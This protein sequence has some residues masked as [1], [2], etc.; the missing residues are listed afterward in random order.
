M[1]G[2]DDETRELDRRFAEAEIPS[3]PEVVFHERPWI[4]PGNYEL[5]FVDHKAIVMKWGP[6]LILTFCISSG[7]HAGV[8]LA[9]FYNVDRFDARG[10]PQ[11]AAAR[12]F[13]REMKVLFPGRSLRGFA[14]KWLREV[15]V[16]ASVV[17]VE[18]TGEVYSKIGKLIGSRPL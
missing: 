12:D 7:E 14:W 15:V 6:K 17:D 8:E 5:G 1:S 9:R 4:P 10:R 18:Q 13:K 3:E 2:T 16:T 11:V